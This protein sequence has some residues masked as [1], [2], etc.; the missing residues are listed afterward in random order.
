MTV[1]RG[2]LQ[3]FKPDYTKY[4]VRTEVHLSILQREQVDDFQKRYNI[5]DRSKAIAQLI[6][7]ALVL[8][9][10]MGMAETWTQK[11]VQE[12]KQ[13][14][15]TGQMVDWLAQMPW[16]KFNIIANIVKSEQEIRA[17]GPK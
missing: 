16:E 9:S 3:D 4:K 1:Y 17:R 7:A 11:D 14:L 6:D 10:K 2:K 8:E 15:E 5:A 13:Q 12:M